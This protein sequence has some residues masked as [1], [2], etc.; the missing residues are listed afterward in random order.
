MYT[1]RRNRRAV[2]S[3]VAGL[4]LT[5]GVASS[6]GAAAAATAST[7]KTSAVVVPGQFCLQLGS[8]QR[9]MSTAT[10]ANRLATTAAEWAKLE[11]AAPQAI[12]TDVNAIRIAY[13]TAV[14][15]KSDA[16]TKAASVV[17]AGKKVTAYVSSNCRAPQGVP[18]NANLAK[19][20]A[21]V[22]AKGSKLPDFGG[23][24]AGGAV[25][26]LD[27]KTVAALQACGLRAA[28]SQN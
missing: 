6:S 9:A 15:A 10:A 3:F 1:Y 7:S 23:A 24:G 26:Q 4:S 19:I 17:A 11:R 25:P 5:V 27:Q 12:K 16:A 8:S 14:R 28:P 20:K 21:C 22:E 13:D 18:A 2:R